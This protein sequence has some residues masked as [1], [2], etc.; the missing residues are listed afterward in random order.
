MANNYLQFSENLASLTVDEAEWFKNRLSGDQREVQDEHGNCDTFPDFQWEIMPPMDG[1]GEVDIWFYAEEAGEPSHVAEVVQ[2]FFQ[3]FPRWKDEIWTLTW[4]TTCSKPR[5]SE[6]S[7]GGVVVTAT[8]C[9]YMEVGDWARR[10]V[11]ELKALVPIKAPPKKPG[12][13]KNRKKKS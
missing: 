13:K 6:F 3:K 9:F 5:P 7:G 10:K 4:A 11:D 2:E 1:V 8:E 12:I